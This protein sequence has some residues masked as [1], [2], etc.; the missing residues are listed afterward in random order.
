MPNTVAFDQSR[1]RSDED[2]WSNI[3]MLLR[4]LCDAGCVSMVRYEDAGIYVVEF[5]SAD[6]SLGDVYPYWLTP[7]QFETVVFDKEEETD[8]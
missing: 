3:T 2:M 5:A 4:S 6:Q 1:Y 8:V 7:E